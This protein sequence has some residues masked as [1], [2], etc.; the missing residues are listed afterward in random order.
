M[1]F[2]RTKG[3]WYVGKTGGTVVSDVIVQDQ[4][5]KAKLEQSGHYDTNHYGGLLICESID[6]IADAQLIADAGNVRQQINFDL[7][8][9]LEQRNKMLEMLNILVGNI[10][11]S[12]MPYSKAEKLEM[13]QKLIKESNRF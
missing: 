3:K 8:E 13:A 6:K 7:P 2:K 5:E 1:E 12:P 10:D 9:L 11:R 4:N